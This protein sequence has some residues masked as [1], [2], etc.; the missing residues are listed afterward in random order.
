MLTVEGGREE[1]GAVSRGKVGGMQRRRRVC[2]PKG[3]AG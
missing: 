1:V 3:R 2:P